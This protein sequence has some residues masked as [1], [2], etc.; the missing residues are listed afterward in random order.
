VVEVG[1][2]GRAK[3]P[4][5]EVCGK[6]G[7]AQT[8]SDAYMKAH[9]LETNAWFVGFAP[10]KDPQIVVVAL[11]E[12]GGHGQFAAQLVRDVMKAYFD[13]QARL[14][15]STERQAVAAPPA[16]LFFGPIQ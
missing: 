13:K 1:T 9:H 10:R 2:G 8:G 14:R 5:I 15:L 11:Y 7:S 6:T 12:E 3:L 16:L 4:G